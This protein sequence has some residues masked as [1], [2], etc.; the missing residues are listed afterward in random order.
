MPLGAAQLVHYLLSRGSLTPDQVVNGHVSL[1]GAQR[2]NYNFKLRL[3]RGGYFI[4]QASDTDP[5][6]AKTLQHE[7]DFYQAIESSPEIARLVPRCLGYDARGPLLVLELRENAESLGDFHRRTR[8]FTPELGRATG[9][10]LGRFHAAALETAQARPWPSALPHQLPWVLSLHEQPL[11]GFRMASAANIQLVQLLKRY[12]QFGRGL[13]R[14]RDS[15]SAT[16]PIHGDLKWD[17]CLVAHGT[18][19]LTVGFV[20]FEM[21]DHGDPLWD[22]GSLLHSYLAQWI[23]AM[24]AAPRASDM[25]AAAPY[26]IEA[27]QGCLQS[28]WEG[29]AAAAG[30]AP[31]RRLESLLKCVGFAGARLIQTGYEAM[32]SAT[33]PS[34]S[35]LFLLQASMNIMASPEDAARD[36]LELVTQDHA[37]D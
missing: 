32:V 33:E 3:D 8:T 6:A 2:R 5:S 9:A 27:M 29:Y 7:R 30:I 12:P 10:A 31:E 20:D 15:W 34:P 23:L 17:N 22:V 25:I 35:I 1:V 24:P 37:G 28:L 36:L 19:G 4:K 13:S 18:A 26:P 16:H 21:A 14:L 11:E